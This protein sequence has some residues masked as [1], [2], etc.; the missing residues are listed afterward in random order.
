MS[1][2]LTLKYFVWFYIV[3]RKALPGGGVLGVQPPEIVFQLR[4]WLHKIDTAVFIIF[5]FNALKIYSLFIYSS[6]LQ[7][8]F[9]I[10][11]NPITNTIQKDLNIKL[12]LYCY[13]LYQMLLNL[14]QYNRVIDY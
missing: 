1:N 5:L 7:S 8:S 6:S 10:F 3:T 2:V 9:Y 13:R 11:F 4:P 12:K 14:I